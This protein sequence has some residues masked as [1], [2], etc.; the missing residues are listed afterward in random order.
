M[1]QLL[2]QQ[3]S[4]CLHAVKIIIASNLYDCKQQNQ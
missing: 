1:L 3:A 2:F 4:S